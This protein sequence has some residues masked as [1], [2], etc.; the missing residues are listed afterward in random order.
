MNETKT[1]RGL[2][3]RRLRNGAVALAVSIVAAA[4]SSGAHHAS[5]ASARRPSA[6]SAPVTVRFQVYPGTLVNLV[7]Y[8][9]S[10]QG[11][12]ADNGIRADLVPIASSPAGA[13]ALA[14]GSID[15]LS[16]SPDA[17]L[18]FV[19]KGLPAEVIAGQS[20]QI[21]SLIVRRGL[22]ASG[23]FPDDLH[24]LAGKTVGITAL[25]SAGQALVEAMLEDAGMSPTSVTF[26]GV[27]A[28]ATALAAFEKGTIDALSYYAP[29]STVPVLEH[30]AKVLANV[31]VPGQGPPGI[32]G[33]DYVAEW[34]EPSFASAHPSVVAGIRR[35]MAQ[36]SVWMHDPA[37][38]PRLESI[39]S[40]IV[41]SVV[42]SADLAAFTEDNL[43][44]YDTA[45]YSK[46]SL[47]TWDRFDVQYH[48]LAHL[49]PLSSVYAPGTPADYAA[50]QR[51]ARS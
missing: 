37:N 29:V 23:T 49:V 18:P 7:T 48:F 47:S 13:A 25:G 2:V 20:K 50:V 21:F 22:H 12:F 4:C 1:G 15:V 40:G 16:A 32:A 46:A 6:T 11:F 43:G 5:S 34:V 26:V 31:G 38:L 24:V 17:A 27:G 9:A 44:I 8:V 35:A 14:S 3:R 36:A 51:L 42:P 28:A 41:G 33:A 30:Q 45:A 10:E 19:E 39:V